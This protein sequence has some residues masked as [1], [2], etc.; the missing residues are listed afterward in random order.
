[1]PNA[2]VCKVST[3]VLIEN[4]ESPVTGTGALKEESLAEEVDEG[5]KST[6]IE[7][8]VL[9]ISYWASFENGPVTGI[10]MLIPPVPYVFAKNE[11]SLPIEVDPSAEAARAGISIDPIDCSDQPASLTVC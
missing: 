5:I 7:P 9:K 10:R 4:Q 8:R 1:M 6:V 11:A 2:T 3:L